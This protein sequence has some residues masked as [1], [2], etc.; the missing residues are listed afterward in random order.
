MDFWDALFALDFLGIVFR[1]IIKCNSLM[2]FLPIGFICIPRFLTN[3]IL[4][5]VET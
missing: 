4:A 2:D 1:F 5:C 3:D